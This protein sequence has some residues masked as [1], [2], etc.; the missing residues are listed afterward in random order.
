MW[1]ISEGDIFIFYFYLMKLVSYGPKSD[2]HM[3]D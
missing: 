1:E 3:G 2:A